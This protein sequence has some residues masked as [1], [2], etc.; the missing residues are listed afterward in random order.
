M[1]HL[2][3]IYFL[4]DLVTQLRQLSLSICTRI[5]NLYAMAVVTFRFMVPPAVENLERCRRLPRRKCLIVGRLSFWQ[6]RRWMSLAC[7]TML[8][9]RLATAWATDYLVARISTGLTANFSMCYRVFGSL[10]YRWF[11]G[12]GGRVCMPD[13]H[14]IFMAHL[15]I[16]HFL[17]LALTFFMCS[18]VCVI[19][20]SLVCR[21]WV[22]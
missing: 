5:A 18:H 2:Y 16:Y 8:G 4:H 1:H 14:T 9:F 21:A 7:N 3:F 15:Y 11:N 12:I 22:Y 20:I 17:V 6:P 10:N 13:T 19:S